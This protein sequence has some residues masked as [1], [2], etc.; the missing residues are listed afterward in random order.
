MRSRCRAGPGC[1]LGLWSRLQP[2]NRRVIGWPCMATTPFDLVA[3]A[4]AEMI[5][6]GFHPDF[7]DG[8]EAQVAE[9]LA[10]LGGANGGGAEDLR[11]LLW[12]SIDNDT[13][14]DLD[15]IEVA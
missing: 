3:S 12:S 15:Q 13:S 2:R 8:T 6:E 10:T 7:P 9:I 5:R 11:S 14:R 4:S 1:L